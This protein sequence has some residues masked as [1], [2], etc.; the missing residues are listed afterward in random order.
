VSLRTAAITESLSHAKPTF[1]VNLQPV[2]LL[3]F[4]VPFFTEDS[5]ISEFRF[6]SRLAIPEDISRYKTSSFLEML[7][8]SVR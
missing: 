2:S 1:I 4:N 5:G 8:I 6:L 3:Q 7:A